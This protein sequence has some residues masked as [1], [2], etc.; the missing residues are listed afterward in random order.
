MMGP[1]MNDICICSY[2]STGFGLAAKNHIRALS[3]FSDII[4]VQEH[5]LLDAKDKN[6]SNAQKIKSEFGNIFD[7]SIV[8]AV[9]EETQVSR[10]RGKGG[11]VTLWKKNLTQFV[12]KVNNVGFRIQTTTFKFSS[13]DFLLIICYFPCDPK[14]ENADDSELLNLL[15]DIRSIIMTSQCDNVLI[16]GDLNCHFDRQNSFTNTIADTFA[17]LGIT[18]LWNNPNDDSNHYI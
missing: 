1:K 13:G 3:L 6:H 16:V 10:G 15:A 18:F 17:N 12:T 8:P 5:F 9:K 7:M 14:K 4:C 11:L 2:N